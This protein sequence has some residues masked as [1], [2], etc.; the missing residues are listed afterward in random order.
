MSLRVAFPKEMLSEP[1]SSK[2][3]NEAEEL[4]GV[5]FPPTLRAL[6]RE[7]D[8]FREPKG[9]SKYLLS[10]TNDDFIGS[11]L[12]ITQS[13]WADR[14]YWEPTGTDPHQYVFFGFSSGGEIWG[15]RIAAP[16]D[17]I[18]YH[19]NQEDEVTYLGSDIIEI[20]RND[21]RKYED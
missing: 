16:H 8:G 15:I 5:K 20:F 2:A 3:I 19:H 1:A 18:E 21:F 6:Y 12:K 14:L 17:V 4:L 13:N 7:C 9:N 11:L 10:L